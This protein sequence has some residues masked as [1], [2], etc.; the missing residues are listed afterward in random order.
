MFARTKTVAHVHGIAIRID[1]TWVVIAALIGASLWARFSERPHVSPWAAPVMALVGAG[2]FFGS[3]LLHELG[4]ALEA[5]RHGLEVRSITLFL[6]GGVTES[7]FRFRRPADELVMVAAGPATSFALSGLFGVVAWWA[8]AV[9]VEAVA[10]VAAVLAWVNL[11]LGAFNLVP[12]VPLDGGRI[13]QALVWRAT[14]D[15]RR[16]MVVAAGV[17]RAIAAGMIGVGAALLLVVPGGAVDGLW[18]ALIGWFLRRSATAEASFARLEGTLAGM[19]LRDLLPPRPRPLDPWASVHDAELALVGAHDD[20]LL[21]VIDHGAV[22]GVVDVERLRSVPVAQ[23]AAVPV[24]AVTEPA[25]GLR[26][27][28]GDADAACLLEL[29]PSVPLVVV[30]GGHELGVVAPSRAVAVARR[31]AVAARR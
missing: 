24:S 8:G 22:R 17:G 28:D 23:R 4:H 13:L 5:Q 27:V 1:A 11:A 10:A 31:R 15:R 29:P 18:L 7:S 21:C 3:L 30:A 20:D 2:L 19:A 14:G 16:S 12:G 25:A 6:F 26:R 9:G